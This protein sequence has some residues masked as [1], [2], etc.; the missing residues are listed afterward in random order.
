MSNDNSE[1]SV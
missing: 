1:V